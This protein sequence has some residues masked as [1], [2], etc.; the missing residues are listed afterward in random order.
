VF[1]LKGLIGFFLISVN[2]MLITPALAQTV[3]Q[4][5]TEKYPPYTYEEENGE[6]AGIIT[7][8]VHAIAAKAGITIQTSVYPWARAYNMAIE[9]PNILIFSIFKTPEREEQFSWIGPVIPRVEIGLYKLKE[10]TDITVNSLED[11]K[12]YITGVVRDTIF[13]TYLLDHG[14]AKT[15][16]DVQADPLQNLK[17]LFLKRID[18]VLAEEF[19]NAAQLQKLNL[20]PDQMEEVLRL[21][22]MNTEFYVAISKQTSEDIVRKLQTAFKEIEADGATIPA[23]LEKY[24]KPFNI[25]VPQAP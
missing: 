12:N 19:E 11:A 13:H 21:P 15:S 4:G 2:L 18:L 25:A 9:Q 10:R 3:L 8:I 16:I 22:D 7:E 1:R 23:I 5:V 6:V 20:P 14:F 24:R 17:L